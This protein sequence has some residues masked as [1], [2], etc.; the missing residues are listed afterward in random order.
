MHIV[1]YIKQTQLYENIGINQKKMESE[2][3]KRIHKF[4]KKEC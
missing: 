4:I 1:F 3:A 2:L